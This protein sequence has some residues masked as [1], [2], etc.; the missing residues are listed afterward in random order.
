[1]KF[2]PFV[3]PNFLE[4]IAEPASLFHSDYLAY[5]RGK[6]SRAELVTR[7]PHIAM[8]GDSVCMNIYISSSWSTLW[9]ARTSLR[10]NWFLHLDTA[11]EELRGMV[12]ELNR[13]LVR[14]T[15]Q[16]QRR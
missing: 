3:S 6:I 1:M 13:E 2:V 10:K 14:Q 9:R 5:R 4:R 8:V 16:I 11:N 12:E 15:E 7:L